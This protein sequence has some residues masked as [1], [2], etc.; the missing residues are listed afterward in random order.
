MVDTTFGK[1]QFVGKVTG[2]VTDHYTMLK[3]IYLMK[4]RK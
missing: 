1:Q 2:I 4:F 3:V